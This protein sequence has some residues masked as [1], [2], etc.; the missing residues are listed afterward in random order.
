MDTLNPASPAA[1]MIDVASQ[2]TPRVWKFWGTTLWGILII[3]AFFIAQLTPIGYFLLR[4]DGPL[5]STAQ[6][7][8]ALIQIVG[9]PLTIPLSAIIGLPGMLIPTY[10]AI[11][12]TRIPFTD[13]LGLH[14]TTLKNLA[15]GVVGM[16]LILG[17]WEL[18]EQLTG[19]EET[20]AAFMVDILKTVQDGGLVWLLIVAFCVVAPISEEL[21]ARGFL[22][23]GWSDS[24]LRVPGA[25]ILSSLAW[26]LLHLQ[27]DWFALLHVLSLG[28][29]FGYLR[30]RT[31]SILLT[32]VLHGLNNLAAT[33]QIMWL[34]S[35][36]G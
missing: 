14:W 3:I 9:Q 6:L 4:Y 27:Y 7:E 5:D 12:Y 19:R 31:D 11:R 8:A 30:Y 20:S 36:Q 21:L 18:V 26:T 2:P 1:A 22:Y 25:I 10:F 15:L 29:W 28:L 32:M 17:G 23:R 35:G 24:F 33:V 16:V 34:A 13:Y